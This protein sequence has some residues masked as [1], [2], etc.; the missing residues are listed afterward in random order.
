MKIKVSFIVPVYNV[1]NYLE[2][3]LESILKQKLVE[4]EIVIVN[5]GSTDGSLTIIQKFVNKHENI[6]VINQVNRGI[7]AA[8]NI[9][10]KAA[11]GEYVCFIDSDDYYLQ[12]FAEE[13]YNQC[14]EHKLDIIRGFYSI[15]N[16]ETNLLN[17][18]KPKVSYCYECLSGT[19]FLINSISEHA[20]EVVP[21]LGFYRKNYLIENNILFPEGIG[22]EE[23][24]L[25][26]LKALLSSKQCKVMQTDHSFYAYRYRKGSVTKN[27]HLKQAKDVLYIVEQELKFISSLALSYRERKYA[28]KFISGSFYQLTSIYGRINLDDRKVLLKL[29]PIRIKLICILY[30]Y[31]KH[32]FIKILLFS[33]TPKVVDLIYRYKIS[34]S[35]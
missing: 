3:C 17:L 27:P 1:E 2:E 11:R 5:D 34:S 9:G 24:Q 19:Q 26:F 8:R 7:S 6:Q 12:D 33:F 30:A 25:F 4:K 35:I 29:I 18:N 32:Q 10:L 28:L 20:N 13:Y 23:D 14:I 16:D 22:Y 21:W 31:D 15:Y